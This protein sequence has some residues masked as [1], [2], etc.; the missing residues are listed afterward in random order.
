MKQTLDSPH[1]KQEQEVTLSSKRR[2][3]S[4]LASILFLFMDLV[5]GKKKTLSKFKVLEVIARVPYQSWEHVAYIAMTHTYA[6]PDFARR[7]F[8][9]VREARS[10]QDNEQWHLLILEELTQKKGIKESFFL[11]RILPQFMAFFYYHVSWLLY[12]MK[13]SWSYDLN[14]DFEDHAEH[15]YMEFVKENPQLEQ[16][17][18]ESEFKQ[19]YGEFNS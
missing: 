1:L 5:Y 15:E 8:E 9:F 11:Y 12:V 18:F 13:P 4:F 2:S 14:A 10:Q 19:D 17:T 3:Y 7:I 16:E 6:K